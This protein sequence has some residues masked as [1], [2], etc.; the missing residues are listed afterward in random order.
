MTAA[1]MFATWCQMANDQCFFVFVA[2]DQQTNETRA[3][4][5]MAAG[6]VGGVMATLKGSP[7]SHLVY[8]AIVAGLVHSPFTST[9]RDKVLSFSLQTTCCE[10]ATAGRPFV[11]LDH[12]WH[13]PAEPAVMLD[14]FCIPRFSPKLR[15]S[16]KK[17]QQ[18]L[19][20][21]WSP[22]ELPS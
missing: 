12:R 17:Q 6:Q 10:L 9:E 19:R 13:L 20:G 14:F 21:F 11:P 8:L 16:V 4:S 3:L 22:G 1:A 2:V 15:I 5:P 18:K 7:G